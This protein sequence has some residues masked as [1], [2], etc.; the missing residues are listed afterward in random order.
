[1]GQWLGWLLMTAKILKA[2][3]QVE[4]N[5]THCSLTDAELDNPIHIA[6]R[7]AFMTQLNT[8]IGPPVEQEDLALQIAQG[9][10]WCQWHGWIPGLFAHK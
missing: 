5:A 9:A 6:A 10:T 3:G 7:Y 8:V 4:Q 2:T 1:L